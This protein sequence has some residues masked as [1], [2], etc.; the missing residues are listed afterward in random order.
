[1]NPVLSVVDIEQSVDLKESRINLA[2]PQGK[3][4][5]EVALAGVP[6]GTPAMWRAVRWRRVPGKFKIESCHEP[7]EVNLSV[8]R[9]KRS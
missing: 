7:I 6:S 3:W 2:L 1:M 4:I 9:R 5:L 8:K